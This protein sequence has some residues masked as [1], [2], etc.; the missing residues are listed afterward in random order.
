MVT[1]S[2][3]V[4]KSRM[5]EYFRTVEKT[6]EELVVTDH[7]VPVLKVTPYKTRKSI[8]EV[9]KDIRDKVKIKGD[10]TVPTTDEWGENA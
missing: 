6:G 1:V 9:F 2:K 10:L 4:L 8:A 3:G 5:L 7:R